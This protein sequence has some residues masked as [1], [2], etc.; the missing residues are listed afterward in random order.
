[1]LHTLQAKLHLTFCAY[2]QP[3]LQPGS[4]LL[5]SMGVSRMI[6]ASEIVAEVRLQGEGNVLTRAPSI[7]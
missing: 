5:A 4:S 6:T 7:S 1:M 3:S 2:A